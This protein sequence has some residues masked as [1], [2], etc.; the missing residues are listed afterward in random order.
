LIRFLTIVETPA[1]K[2]KADSFT[3]KETHEPKNPLFVSY[4]NMA[5]TFF[6]VIITTYN[7]SEILIR[8]VKS[9]IAQTES[10]WEAIII[11]DGSTD[12]TY[13]RLSKY[14]KS[15]PS[16]FYIKQ[17]N[18]GEEAAK[19]TGIR[20][21]SGSYITFLDS[22]DFYQRDHLKIRKSILQE[23]PH[24]DLL[25]G[26]VKII[27]DKYVPDRF[28]PNKRIHLSECV[29]GGTF[30]I[31]KNLVLKLNGFQRVPIGTDADLFERIS[32]R[33]AKIKKIHHPTYIYNRQLPD[34]L[35]HAF[36]RKHDR[37][38]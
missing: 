20:A 1:L 34:S 23:H 9:L 33:G 25:H 27:G 3:Q 28:N 17:K 10:D 36:S 26:G 18:K 19:N 16:I 22:D 4:T 21:A 5:N 15:H 6:S 38:K 13:S 30:F 37:V 7:R 11:D 24:I 29:I 14:L 2:L 8:A 12:D 32:R 35:T 31:R